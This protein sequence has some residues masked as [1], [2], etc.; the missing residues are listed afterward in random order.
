MS[1]LR[2]RMQ[3]CETRPGSSSGWLVPWM[4]MN[5]PPASRSASP[6]ARVVPNASGRRPASRSRVSRLRT[7]NA[8][9]GV[10]Q[11]RC[12]DPDPR[13]E[14]RAAPRARAARCSAPAVDDQVRAHDLVAAEPVARGP[15][16]W[17][18]WAA[19]PAAPDPEHAADVAA[20]EQRQR[21]GRALRRA[22]RIARDAR[23]PRPAPHGRRR[24][25]LDERPAP[26]VA[27]GPL[28]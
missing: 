3:P 21:L 15:S 11:R 16:R 20:S 19:P 28:S 6:S 13:A 5:P 24:R 10:G 26:E 9:R 7:M 17:C 12:A 1:R 2:I 25:A 4:P 23:A 8:P 14:D 22:R 27:A 18:R